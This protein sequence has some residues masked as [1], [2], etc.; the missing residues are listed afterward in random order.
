MWSQSGRFRVGAFGRNLAEVAVKMFLHLMHFK[1]KFYKCC[2]FNAIC[3]NNAAT[4]C[5]IVQHK[6]FRPHHI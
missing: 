3:K 6:K 1:S 5:V 4:N 2:A